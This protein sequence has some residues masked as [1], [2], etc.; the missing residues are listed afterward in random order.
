MSAEQQV[1]APAQV[2]V[3][4][5]IVYVQKKSSKIVTYCVLIAVV[6]VLLWMVKNPQRSIAFLDRMCSGEEDLVIKYDS[7]ESASWWPQL[8]A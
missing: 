6:L 8:I 5:E 7:P 2:A 3:M 1:E 4:R